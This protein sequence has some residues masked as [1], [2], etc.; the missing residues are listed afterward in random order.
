MEEIILDLVVKKGEEYSLKTIINLFGDVQ[1]LVTGNGKLEVILYSPTENSETLLSKE[2]KSSVHK[3]NGEKYI[4]LNIYD[5][6]YHLKIVSINHVKEQVN[7]DKF[8]PETKCGFV[9]DHGKSV[10]VFDI[11]NSGEVS[12]IKSVTIVVV[13]AYRNKIIM[14]LGFIVESI[15]DFFKILN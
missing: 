5:I 8:I 3:R 6:P 7:I 14:P 12:G 9:R 11:R 15:E 1:C 4:S 2:K 10:L 13:N